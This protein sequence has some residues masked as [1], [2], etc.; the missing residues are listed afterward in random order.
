[1]LQRLSLDEFLEL[2]QTAKRVAV[3][4]VISAD[5][6]TPIGVVESLAHEMADGT[7]LESGLYHQDVGRHSFIAFGPVAQFSVRNRVV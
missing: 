5:R 6:L 1:M 2:A 7:I 3:H 4:R